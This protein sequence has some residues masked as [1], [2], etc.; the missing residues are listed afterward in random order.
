MG[1]QEADHVRWL[2]QLRW[3]EVEMGW[4]LKIRETYVSC[5]CCVCPRKITVESKDKGSPSGHPVLLRG[6]TWWG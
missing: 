1:D 3:A 4:A 2:R 6:R 5:M